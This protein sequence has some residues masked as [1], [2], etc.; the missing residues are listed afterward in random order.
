ML[1]FLN[2]HKINLNDTIEFYQILVDYDKIYFDDEFNAIY[3]LVSNNQNNQKFK[4]DLTKYKLIN[5]DCK[6]KIMDHII[7]YNIDN[8]NK[9]ENQKNNYV[10]TAKQNFIDPINNQYGVPI[11]LH[12]YKQVSE[13]KLPN[14]IESK[15]TNIYE[16]NFQIYNID[17]DNFQVQ[18]I[19]ET[20]KL[21][22]INRK[23]FIV[24]NLNLIQKYYIANK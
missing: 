9:N 14:L 10:F 17:S 20:N 8:Q 13:K 15:Y 3:S 2:N 23:Y 18:F 6:I 21:T 11:F 5:I 16:L 7:S 24:P 12:I 1:W 4:I 22:N 19:V